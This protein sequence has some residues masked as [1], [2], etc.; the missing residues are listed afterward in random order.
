[1]RRDLVK[2]SG[3]QFSGGGEPRPEV[4]QRLPAGAFTGRQP[5]CLRQ[6]EFRSRTV[7]PPGSQRARRQAGSGH[8]RSQVPVLLPRRQ[9]DSV[10]RRQRASESARQRWSAATRLRRSRWERG[11]QLGS[12]RYDCLCRGRPPKPHLTRSQRRT[13]KI[14]HRHHYPPKP[15]TPRHPLHA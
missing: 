7:I 2:L 5:A 13:S 3:D 8:Q 12:E 10:L 9:M 6:C 15:K 4:R 14:H 1:M 11:R